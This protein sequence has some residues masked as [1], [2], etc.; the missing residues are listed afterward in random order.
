MIA[1]QG[2][3]TVIVRMM[4]ERAP[5]NA[6]T[7]VNAQGYTAVMYAA[8]Y[9]HADIVRLLVAHGASV[10]FSRSRGQEAGAYTRSLLSS[11]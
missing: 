6:V 1:S 9:H 4:L 11:T 8:G 7:F 2:G 3:H 10:H 5:N